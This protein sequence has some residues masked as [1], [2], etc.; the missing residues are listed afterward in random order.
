MATSLRTGWNKREFLESNLTGNRAALGES[1]R[2]GIW[3]GG[4]NTAV[5]NTETL[6]LLTAAQVIESENS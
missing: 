1:L 2:Q 6:Q 3:Q 4:G 5:I